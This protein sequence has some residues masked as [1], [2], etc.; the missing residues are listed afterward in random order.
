MPS[1]FT[2]ELLGHIDEMFQDSSSPEFKPDCDPSRVG[3]YAQGICSAEHYKNEV[4]KKPM[5][6]FR[7]DD[8]RLKSVLEG[9]KWKDTLDIASSELDAYNAKLA[10]LEEEFKQLN[11]NENLLDQK[12]ELESFKADASEPSIDPRADDNRF[13]TSPT[14]ELGSKIRKHASYND[15]VRA[16]LEGSDNIA[17]KSTRIELSHEA[18]RSLKLADELASKGNSE[19]SELFIELAYAFTD[20][21]LQGVF[22]AFKS[23][24][25]LAVGKNLVTGAPYG[26]LDYALGILDVLSLGTAGMISSSP[27]FVIK[28]IRAIERFISN[29]KKAAALVEISSGSKLAREISGGVKGGSAFEVFN[30]AKRVLDSAR[31]VGLKGDEIAGVTKEVAHMAGNKVDDIYEAAAKNTPLGFGSTGRTV[32]NDLK[33]QAAMLV[34]RADPQAGEILPI[35][36]TDSRWPATEGW[37]KMQTIFKTSDNHSVVIH[38]VR[39]KITGKVDDFKFKN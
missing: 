21:A 32:P 15:S 14:S 39:N 38:Y 37:Q 26:K 28:S 34:T 31:K 23:L 19:E 6:D 17:D 11:L 25:E 2:K 9:K 36:L 35:A 33:E 20:L 1:Y 30:G 7:A 12:S 13:N 4:F 29:K 22:G 10:E 8:E 18:D 5:S 3:V 24:A 27:K 16:W